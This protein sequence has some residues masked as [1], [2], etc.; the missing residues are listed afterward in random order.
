M[1]RAKSQTRGKLSIE[2]SGCGAE[3]FIKVCNDADRGTGEF[4]FVVTLATKF[5]IEM[6]GLL[7][8]MLFDVL[9]SGRR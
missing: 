4:G 5:A 2:G 8:N 9:N 3:N 6:R 1:S 7:L